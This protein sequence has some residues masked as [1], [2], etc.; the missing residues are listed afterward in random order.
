MQQETPR[1]FERVLL[2]RWFLLSLLGATVLIAVSYARAYYQDYKVRQQISSLE[3]EV[4]TLQRKKLVSLDLLEQ[5]G[6]DEFLESKAKTQLNLKKPDE[7]VMAI[8]E[9]PVEVPQTVVATSTQT[10]DEPVL[11]NPRKWWYYFTKSNF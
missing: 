7:Q 9:I 4:L 6:T 11:S 1:A 10:V 2:S 3:A 5:A 8:P